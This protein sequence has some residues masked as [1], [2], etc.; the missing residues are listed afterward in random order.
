VDLLLVVLS[1]SEISARVIEACGHGAWGGGS[2]GKAGKTSVGV[3][4]KNHCLSMAVMRVGWSVSPASVTSAGMSL[5]QWPN[6]HLAAV[7]R[8]SRVASWR[9]LFAQ[10]RFTILT[11][12]HRFLLA[13]LC[14]SGS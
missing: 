13:V 4:L 7:H 2:S 14:V 3:I 9:N 1:T 5:C 6:C 10:F 12:F 8:H 11:S